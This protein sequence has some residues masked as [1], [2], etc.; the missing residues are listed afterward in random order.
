MRE[1]AVLLRPI[2]RFML[3]LESLEGVVRMVL[4]HIFV[5]RTAFRTPFGR[6]SMYTFAILLSPVP[7]SALGDFHK[8]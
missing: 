6:G 3:R 5:Y 8:A 4:D 7:V 2:D 1:V